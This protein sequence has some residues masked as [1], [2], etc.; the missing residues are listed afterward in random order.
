MIVYGSSR[1]GPVFSLEIDK[2]S[3]WAASI[4]VVFAEVLNMKSFYTRFQNNATRPKI[5]T[6]NVN[7]YILNRI[8]AIIITKMS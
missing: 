3:F 5:A 1:A 4:Q 7:K 6:T 8:F 2:A